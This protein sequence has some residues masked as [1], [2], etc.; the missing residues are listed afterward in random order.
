[1]IVAPVTMMTAS[2]RRDVLESG[3]RTPETIAVN[4]RTTNAATYLVLGWVG[5]F[6]TARFVQSM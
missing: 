1:M 3:N 6:A 4:S 5:M 2:R